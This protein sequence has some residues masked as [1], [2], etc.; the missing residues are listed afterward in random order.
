[1][2]ACIAEDCAVQVSLLESC[3]FEPKTP[4]GAVLAATQCAVFA[5][6]SKL[7]GSACWNEPEGSNGM[8]GVGDWVKMRLLPCGNVA[9]ALCDSCA[10]IA[11]RSALVPC[12]SVGSSSISGAS[13][14]AESSWAIAVQA[15]ASNASAAASAASAASASSSS[16]SM[17][18]SSNMELSPAIP[19]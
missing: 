5:A 8:T 11:F 6:D 18:A 14:S 3:Q 7:I 16:A 4:Q 2:E 9:A 12:L 1:M 17:N 15:S 10:C 19:Y 13:P